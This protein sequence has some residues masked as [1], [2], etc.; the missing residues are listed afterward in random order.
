[1]EEMLKREEKDIQDENNNLETMGVMEIKKE[2]Y[3]LVK[4][5][6]MRAW[7]TAE[8]GILVARGC[9]KCSPFCGR[10]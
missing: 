6:V 10:F 4:C 2:E 7:A 5:L 3:Y 8:I 1:M 9:S